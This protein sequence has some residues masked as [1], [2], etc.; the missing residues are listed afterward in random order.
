M[1]PAF[2]VIVYM[3]TLLYTFF[4]TFFCLRNMSTEVHAFHAN[5]PKPQG[6]LCSNISFTN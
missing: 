6:P 1:T 3:K 2:L 5:N 4:S